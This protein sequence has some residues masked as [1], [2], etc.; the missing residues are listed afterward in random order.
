MEGEAGIVFV[1]ISRAMVALRFSRGRGVRGE[2]QVSGWPAQ[3]LDTGGIRPLN[4]RVFNRAA[5]W[6]RR[7]DCILQVFENAG[8]GDVRG[9]GDLL[10]NLIASR[11]YA[12]CA[13][14]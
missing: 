8:D 12:A 1:R 9:G 10:S 4:R 13:G 2:C 5:C 7:G 3:M 14:G 6:R 11:A